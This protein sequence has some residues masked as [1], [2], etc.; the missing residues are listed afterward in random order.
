MSI[1]SIDLSQGGSI[2]PWEDDQDSVDLGQ[3]SAEVVDPEIRGIKEFL[4]QNREAERRLAVMQSFCE[5]AIRRGSYRESWEIYEKSASVRSLMFDIKGVASCLGLRCY[6]KAEEL[7]SGFKH[8]ISLVYDLYSILYTHKGELDKALQYSDKV[9]ANPCRNKSMAQIRRIMILALQGNFEEVE[10]LHR[11]GQ[12]SG[13][14]VEEFFEI[15]AFVYY[16]MGRYDDAI[17]L[18]HAQEESTLYGSLVY[19]Y[20]LTRLNK[21]SEALAV[22][23]KTV[24]QYPCNADLYVLKGDILSFQQDFMGAYDAYARAS[25]N[26]PHLTCYRTPSFR[27]QGIPLLKELRPPIPLMLESFCRSHF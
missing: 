4:L 24:Q 14:V 1:Y 16:L 8:K 6:S 12:C 7:L 27:E 21:A 15:E 23:D 13:T 26:N 9:L 19:I 2:G 25:S 5:N 18:V 3:E 20:S 10:K 11:L 17:K 22:V